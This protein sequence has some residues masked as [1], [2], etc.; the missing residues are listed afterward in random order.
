[1]KIQKHPIQCRHAVLTTAL[2]NF[3]FIQN[4]LSVHVTEE[5][6]IYL[7]EYVMQQNVISSHEFVYTCRAPRIHGY[8]RTFSYVLQEDEQLYHL[9]IHVIYI[10]RHQSV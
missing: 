2:V 4:V 5:Y 9:V 6:H 10:G 3:W 1:M 8:V 7:Q